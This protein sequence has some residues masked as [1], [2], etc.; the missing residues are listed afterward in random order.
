MKIPTTKSIDHKNIVLA[1]PMNENHV[2]KSRIHHKAKDMQT[3]KR[4]ELILLFF[5]SASFEGYSALEA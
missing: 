2:L 1:E 3:T 5:F 4:A